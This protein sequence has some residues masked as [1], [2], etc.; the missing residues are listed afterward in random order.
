[1]FQKLFRIVGRFCVS[2]NYVSVT[3]FLRCP[4]KRTVIQQV[5]R[6]TNLL[7]RRIACTR[8]VF[9]R[10]EFSN[11]VARHIRQYKKKNAKLIETKQSKC[12]ASKILLI[13]RTLYLVECIIT[14]DTMLTFFISIVCRE[15][16]YINRIPYISIGELR[17]RIF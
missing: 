4:H 3:Y 9:V 14:D 15:I 5:S 13:K 8:I 16:L 10:L 11:N 2:L 12:Q 7:Q 1:M 17:S 6:V